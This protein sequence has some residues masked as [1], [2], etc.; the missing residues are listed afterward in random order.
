MILVRAGTRVGWHRHIALCV[1]VESGENALTAPLRPQ[2]NTIDT[3]KAVVVA[4]TLSHAAEFCNGGIVPA[5][6]S[7]S[8]LGNILKLRLKEL[9][10]NVN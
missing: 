5:F 4:P 9:L 6:L 7:S 10:A 3:R 1:P 8:D 2:V